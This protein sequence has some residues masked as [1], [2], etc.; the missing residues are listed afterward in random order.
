MPI[1]Q[2]FTGAAIA[3]ARIRGELHGQSCFNVMH[4]ATEVVPND[5]DYSN[6]LN[7]LATAILECVTS[8][9]LPG[10]SSEYSLSGVDAKTIM[11]YQS[12]P[13]FVAPATSAVGALGASDASFV[14]AVI[15]GRTGRGGKS[16]RGRHYIPGIPEAGISQSTMTG[17]QLAL[18]VA[19]ASCMAG[20]YVGLSKTDPNW[21]WGVLSRFKNK[22]AVALAATS[23][24]PYS[25]I[26]VNANV[27]SMNSRKLKRGI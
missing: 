20:K 8:A 24:T 19:F 15:S 26:I 5:V 14:A 21:R 16:Y 25:S 22:Q 7:L 17:G 18:I 3:Q 11:P 10:L 27:G 12:D 4:F 23:F 2:N 13:E 9:L 6:L 1:V